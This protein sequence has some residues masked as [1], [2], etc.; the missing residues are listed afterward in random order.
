[1]RVVV[2]DIWA[3]YAQ[4]KKPFTTMSPQT[5]ALPPGTALV[6]LLAAIV[7]LDKQR[8]WEEFNPGKYWLAVGPRVPIKKVVI[9]INL[10]KTTSPK[11]FF[12]YEAHKPSTVEFLKAPAYRCYFHWEHPLFEELERRLTRHEPYYTIS[13]GQACNLANF[14]FRGSFN[15]QKVQDDA[16]ITLNSAVP[17]EMV[18]E[19][20]FTNR[21]IFSNRLPLIMKPSPESRELAVVKDVLFPA[22]G[23][24]LRAR[25]THYY[26]LGDEK[27]TPLVE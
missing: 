27:V 2:F 22:D 15:A 19:M 16:W 9:P 24:P 12:R 8:Y 4:F 18:K 5:F 21:R 20:D 11:H 23:Q 6:G 17:R 7:G 10:L 25:V 13:L 3:D 14:R 26:E 1:M